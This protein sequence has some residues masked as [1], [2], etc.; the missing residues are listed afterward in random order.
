[1]TENLYRR[2]SKGVKRIE[3]IGQEF[4]LEENT[5]SSKDKK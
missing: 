4:K 5:K 3:N 2:E 1:M